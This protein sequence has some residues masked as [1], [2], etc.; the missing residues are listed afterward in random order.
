MLSSHPVLSIDGVSVIPE[1][2]TVQLT[3]P[4]SVQISRY[5]TEPSVS[6]N[7]TLRYALLGGGLASAVGA[8]MYWPANQAAAKEA[9]T[10]AK[11]TAEPEYGQRVDADAEPTKPVRRTTKKTAE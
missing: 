7:S 2:Q 1:L 5:S 3:I 9:V 11:E 10:K 6:S 8:Y 4:K